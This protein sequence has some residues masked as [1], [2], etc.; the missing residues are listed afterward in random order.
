MPEKQRPLRGETLRGGE[1]LTIAE[2][3]CKSN[4]PLAAINSLERELTGFTHGTVSLVI[5]V[6][7]NRITRFVVGRER[8]VVLFEG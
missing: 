1:T 8:S 4:I 5:H 3:G 2:I 6:R 7:D